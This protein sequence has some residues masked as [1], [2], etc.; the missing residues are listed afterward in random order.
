MTRIQIRAGVTAIT[1]L[2]LIG[3]GLVLA[4]IGDR[5]EL[6]L[7]AGVVIGLS[8]GMLIDFTTG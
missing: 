6:I 7:V 4:G 2:S 3:L 1:I 5:D 8:V